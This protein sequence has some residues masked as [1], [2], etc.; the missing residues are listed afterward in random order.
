[1]KGLYKYPQ[2]EFPYARLEAE[3]ARRGKREP[4]FE[5]LDAGVFDGNRY[6]DVEVEYAKAGTDDILIRITAANR[7]P[8]A[9]PLHG[10][11]YARLGLAPQVL[12]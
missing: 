8:D 5:L 1:M 10:H 7:G 11:H 6:F 2:A 9:A 3:N 12:P 4:E